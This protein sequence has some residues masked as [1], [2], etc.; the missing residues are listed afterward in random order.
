MSDIA[1]YFIV[2]SGDVDLHVRA[3][4]NAIDDGLRS[5]GIK[6]WHIEGYAETSW[7]ILDYV[8]V[9]VHIFTHEAR[10]YYD[11]DGLWGDADTEYLGDG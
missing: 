4:S 7:V 1:D 9:V 8:D 10:V 6:P 11:L 2:C 5:I 3:I